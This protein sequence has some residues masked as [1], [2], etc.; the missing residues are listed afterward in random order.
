MS[1]WAEWAINYP[2]FAGA[3]QSIEVHIFCEGHKILRNLRVTFAWHYIAG[4]L[5]SQ[6]K[7]GGAGKGQLN[8]E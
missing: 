4:M 8:S 6:K 1:R 7:S 2:D 3:R 5:Q